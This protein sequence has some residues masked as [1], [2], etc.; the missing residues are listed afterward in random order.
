[1]RTHG[2]ARDGHG[3]NDGEGVALQHRAVHERAGVA[4]VG[5]AAHV[6]HAVVALGVIGELPFGAG[7]EARA[8]PAPQAGL[9]QRVDDLLGRGFLGEDALQGGVAVHAD[10][11]VDGLR[12]DDAAVAQGDAQL[13]LVELGVRQRGDGL[14]LLPLHVEQ[15]L[16]DAALDDVLGHDLVYVVHS[17]PG[18]ARPLGEHHDDGAHSAQAEAAGLDHP[19]LLVHPGGLEG[20]LKLGDELGAFRGGTAGAGAHHDMASDMAH[21]WFLPLLSFGRADGVVLD[22]VVIDQVLLHDG[23]DHLRAQAHVGHL[24]LAGDKYLGHRL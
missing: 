8:A 24:L 2:V 22:H 14:T 20:L 6:L 17:D 12:V 13:V 1:M 3:L 7:G 16:D 11:L 5:V 4:L 10:V 15:A 18:V 21:S 23:G 9:L 19:D